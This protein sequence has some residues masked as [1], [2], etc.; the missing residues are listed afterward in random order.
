MG[1]HPLHCWSFPAPKKLRPFPFL[2]C[3]LRLKTWL[4]ALPSPL[5]L[6]CGESSEAFDPSR[7]KFD[8]LVRNFRAYV[9]C[10][11]AIYVYAPKPE[12]GLAWLYAFHSSPSLASMFAQPQLLVKPGP[13]WLDLESSSSAA[14]RL[15]W[16][17]RPGS[18][19][20]WKSVMLH[21]PGLPSLGKALSMSSISLNFKQLSFLKAST[22]LLPVLPFSFTL[23]SLKEEFIFTKHLYVF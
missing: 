21:L 8:S 20:T 11:K 7:A 1:G 9:T 10:R 17:L 3:D 4:F 18:T 2:A 12:S 15:C 6:F 22:H 5:N 14:T 16:F 19:L 13:F 23:P